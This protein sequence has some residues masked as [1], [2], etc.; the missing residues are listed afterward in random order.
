MTITVHIRLISNCQLIWRG[1]QPILWIRCWYTGDV[2]PLFD[3]K[4]CNFELNIAEDGLKINRN[5]RYWRS[6][7]TIFLNILILVYAPKTAL[8]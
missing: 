6:N 4:R 7:I 8:N 1:T 2:Y 3:I 5:V